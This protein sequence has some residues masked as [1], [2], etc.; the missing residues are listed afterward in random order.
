MIES[1][2]DL[3]K[4]RHI[5]FKTRIRGTAKKPRVSIY[6]SLK[7]LYIQLVDD[8]AG[9]TIVSIS[10]L[11]IDAKEKKLT[12]QTQAEIM[13]AKLAVEAKKKGITKVVFDKSGYPY[14]GI[15]EKMAESLRKSGIKL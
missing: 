3:R 10:D 14:L 5:R 1:R 11:K 4:K 7:H 6:K 12:P 9:K 15:I 13:T 2:N 8:V